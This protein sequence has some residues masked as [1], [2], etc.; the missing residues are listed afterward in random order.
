MSSAPVAPESAESLAAVDLGSNSFHMV[1]AVEGPAGLRL[2]DRLRE[3]VRLAAGLTDDGRIDAAAEERALAAL[4]RFGQR[5]RGLPPARVRVVGTNT[6]RVASQT[7]GFIDKAEQ[8]L[9][10]PIEI[11]S[12]REEAR[13]I[14][15][16]VAHSLAVVPDER[17][18]VIDIGGG[19]TEIVVGRGFA[20]IEAESFHLGCVTA[21]RHYF[22][23]A[24]ITAKS[25]INL[26]DR[27]C[28]TIEPYLLRL[29]AVGWD[30]AIGASGTVRAIGRVLEANG[31][32]SRITRAGMD[33][34][35]E[36]M[37]DSRH[38][39]RLAELKGLKADRV[40]VLAGGFGIL[41]GLMQLLGLAELQ[42]ADGALREG[43]LYDLL[44]RIHHEDARESS[45]QALQKRFHVDAA[46]NAEIAGTLRDF[47]DAAGRWGLQPVHWDWLRWAA[48]THDIGLDIAHSGFHRHSEYILRHADLAGFSR[49]EQTVLAVLV[50]LQRKTLP[51]L[52]SD[53]FSELSAA[54]AVVVQRLAVLLRLGILFHRGQWVLPFQPG[55]RLSDK[56]TLR[57]DL[58]PNW[59]AQMPLL[60][61]DLAV[62]RELLAPHF[63]LRW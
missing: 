48:A 3:G 33:W 23:Q 34:L 21:T 29:R 30:Q 49:R 14:Y 42:I 53:V 60:A 28:V 31:F 50:R 6:L 16:G 40:P 22:P 37:L 56:R 13:L 62:E 15:L 27:V 12:G 9:G 35:R 26:E 55:L 8:A 25:L 24:E 17:R 10:F 45:I 58:P 11:I 7:R 57:L 51:P 19:S 2:V 52:Y 63:T 59:E 54:D 39:A 4:G 38:F 43:V 44:G 41:N 46:R 5:L 32:G 1:L 61:A 20:P 36:R 18:L 47:F